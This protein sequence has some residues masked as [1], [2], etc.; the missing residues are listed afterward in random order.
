ML[1][2][3]LVDA[4]DSTLEATI[5]GSFSKLGYLARRRLS[6]WHPPPRLDGRVLLVTGASSGIGRAASVELA[7]LG[8]DLWLVGRDERRLAAAVAAALEAGAEAG[9]RIEGALADLTDERQV[10]ALAA[11]VAG[12]AARLDGLVHNAGVMVPRY[13]TATDGTEMT[14][15]THVLAPFRLSCR[16]LP[17]LSRAVAPVIVTVSSGGMYTQRCDV[18]SMEMGPGDYRGAVAY[19]RAKRAQV[20]LAA[21]W[22][23][24]WGGHGL[25]SYAM[26]PGWV[27]TPG[28]S[29]GL[30][31]VARLGPLL[32]TPQQGADTL[33]WLAADG[34][35]QEG[36]PAGHRGPASPGGIWLDR[37]RRGEYYL[38]RT[39]RS[40]AQRQADSAQLWEWCEAR[41]GA[42][43]VTT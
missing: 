33:V 18:A 30:P 4:A 27:D 5:A 31:S 28:L 9:G 13:R 7:R 15:A 25:A 32:R 19:A 12:A 14:V 11:R 35:R 34:P 17:L 40:A 3:L 29:S 8:A 22:A 42:G 21:E 10:C 38:P 41:T 20:V 1:R 24:R 26:H 39:R 37:R 16:L 2:D 36:M 23:R 6:G 43:P